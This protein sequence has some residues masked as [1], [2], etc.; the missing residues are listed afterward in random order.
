MATP[1]LIPEAQRCGGGQTGA[2]IEVTPRSF[3][4]VGRKAPPIAG[5][6]VG[7][8]HMDRVFTTVDRECERGDIPGNGRAELS[9][10]V[11]R[12][13][14]TFNLGCNEGI[15]RLRHRSTQLIAARLTPAPLD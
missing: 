13:R 12:S 6:V 1:C 8:D 5:D 14:Q 2:R 3:R 9:S 11:A 15:R 7:I 10:D 4:Q